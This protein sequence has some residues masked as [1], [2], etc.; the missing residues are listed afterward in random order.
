MIITSLFCNYSL[1]VEETSWYERYDYNSPEIQNLIK[2]KEEI[3]KE[4][5]VEPQEGKYDL[6]IFMGQSNMV[7]KGGDASKALKGIEGAG[8]ELEFDKTG[9]I[10]GLKPIEEPFG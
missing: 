8:Y 6:V 9:N 4:V 7:G 1:A 10:Q 3:Q 2:E 5:N